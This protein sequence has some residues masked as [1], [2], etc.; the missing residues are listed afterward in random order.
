VLVEELTTNEESVRVIARLRAILAMQICVW[1]FTVV[2]LLKEWQ[3]DPGVS[4]PVTFGSLI[5]LLLL[6]RKY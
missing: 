4:L 2:L 6:A 3:I 5:V 1:G